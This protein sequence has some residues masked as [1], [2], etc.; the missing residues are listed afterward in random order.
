[1]M[2]MCEN[3]YNLL[4]MCLCKN[5]LCLHENEHLS[6]VIVTGKEWK[7]RALLKV[8]LQMKIWDICEQ[9]ISEQSPFLHGFPWK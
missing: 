5:V 4:Q 1:M 3:V 2:W 7:I 6:I 8:V 9:F